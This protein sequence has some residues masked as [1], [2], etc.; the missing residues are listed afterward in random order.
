MP[1]LVLLKP[2]LGQRDEH[3]VIRLHC[4]KCTH[5]RVEHALGGAELGMRMTAAEVQSREG[6][7]SECKARERAGVEG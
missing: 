4:R 6:E 3:H 1:P 2:L 7:A 5:S